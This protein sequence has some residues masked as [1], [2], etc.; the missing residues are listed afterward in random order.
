MKELIINNTKRNTYNSWV[1][2]MPD[3]SY[4]NSYDKPKPDLTEVLEQ[5]P[6]GSELRINHWIDDGG[7]VRCREVWEYD[8]YKKLDGKWTKV[9]HFF[10]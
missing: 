1:M 3:G 10:M 7:G 8:V 9:D 6:D 4:V 5:A 2:R